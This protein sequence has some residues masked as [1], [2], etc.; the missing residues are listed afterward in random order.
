MPTHPNRKDEAEAKFMRP[1]GL[2]LPKKATSP[3][4]CLV[5]RTGDGGSI[6]TCPYFAAVRD[7]AGRVLRC[8][9]Q[10]ESPV[11]YT[12]HCESHVLPNLND[13]TVETVWTKDEGALTLS[14]VMAVRDGLQKQDKAQAAAAA[15]NNK[16]HT[17]PD[18]KVATVLDPNEI[19]EVLRQNF[20]QT[21]RFTTQSKP[22]H[23]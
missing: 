18:M 20:Q 7:A 2:A 17:R 9:R 15:D 22:T 21:E 11:S 16:Q 10:D 8:F 4:Q 23:T 12:L 19:L 5:F 13:S 6:V 3:V 1:F 14:S